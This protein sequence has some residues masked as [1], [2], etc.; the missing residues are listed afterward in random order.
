MKRVGLET[1]SVGNTCRT[2][3]SRIARLAYF[4]A[5]SSLLSA[6]SVFV[7]A[8]EGHKALATKGARVEGNT[9]FLSADARKA[10]GLTTAEVDLKDLERTLTATAT[11]VAPWKQHAFV[12]TKL[13]GRL[14]RILC[15][16]GD[17]VQAGQKLAEIESLELENEQLELIQFKLE[18]ELAQQTLA[19]AASLSG[20]G[21]VAAQDGRAA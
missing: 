20:K 1:T 11:I 21:I 7:W 5:L 8:H 17:R 13:A 15:R 2:G 3:R 4:L 9:V 6:L 14:E 16:P 18:L 12:T 10:L 19:P